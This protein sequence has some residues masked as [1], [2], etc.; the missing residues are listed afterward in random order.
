MQSID[1]QKSQKQNIT[2]KAAC[3]AAENQFKQLGGDKAEITLQS[4]KQK[5]QIGQIKKPESSLSVQIS[6][7]VSVQ[8]PKSV[9]P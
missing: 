2:R 9:L 5:F 1:Q 6:V 7:N 4:L 3:K 8:L